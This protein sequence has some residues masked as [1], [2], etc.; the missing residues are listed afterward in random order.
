MARLSLFGGSKTEE[1]PAELRTILGQMQKEREAFESLILRGQESTRE[2]SRF[3]ESMTGA[4]TALAQLRTQ[5]E[6]TQV[7]LEAMQ[8]LVPTMA[9]LDEQTQS[10]TATQRRME[11][12]ATNASEDV[13][14][15]RADV[16]ELR[17]TLEMALALKNDLTGFLELGGGFKALRID[18]D[19]L[20][21]QLRDL[22]QGFDRVR[23]RQDEIR[24]AGDG[25]VSRLEAFVERHRQLQVTVTGTESRVN[26]LTPTLETLSQAAAQVSETRR[27]LNTVK[28]LGDS[29]SQKVAA[30]E[31]QRDAVDRALGQAAQLNQVMQEIN[32]KVQKQQESAKELGAIEA[33]VKDLVTLHGEALER[34][35]QITARQEEIARADQDLRG[36]LTAARDDV[37]QAVDRFEMENRGLEA[38][39]QRI[40][41]LRAAVTDI[42]GRFRALEESRRAIEEIRARAEGLGT[43]VG[44]MSEEIAQLAPQAE[45]VHAV[46]EDADQLAKAVKDLTARMAQVETTRSTI[47]AVLRDFASLKGTHEALQDATEQMKVAAGEVARVRQEHADT[48]SWLSGTTASVDALRTQMAELDSLKPTVERVRGEAE[49]VLQAA[50]QIESRGKLVEEVQGRLADLTSLGSQLEERTRALQTRMDAADDRFQAVTAHAEEAE[51][52]EKAMPTVVSAV[53]RSERR[54]AEVDGA[55]TALESR[56]VDLEGVA[57]RTRKLGQEVEQRQAALDK[58]SEHLERAAKLREEA[59]TAAQQL[60]ERTGQLSGGLETATG[61]LGDLTERLEELEGR[62]QNLRFMQKRMGQFEERLA[63]W[64]AAEVELARALEQV[65][66]RQAT[67]DTLQA[68]I[69]R[70]FE[71]AE[72]T[73]DDVKA[74][75]AAKQ[76]VTETRALLENVLG[77]VEHAHSVANTL[78]HKKRQVEQAEERVG[79]AEALLIDIQ[80]SLE[81]L[82]GQKAFLDQVLEQAGALQFQAK[83]AEALIDTLRKERDVTDRV[84]A[85]VTELRQGGPVAKGA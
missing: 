14:R 42:E 49:R 30:L 83:Q 9:T 52:I 23:E 60:E 21:A 31:Q 64:E 79:R 69:Q 43:Q 3:G 11:S 34:S 73:V 39:G 65:G 68:G 24:L 36:Q 33:R 51:R 19:H 57:E 5:M 28:A 17:N 4:Q 77:L 62:T 56:R 32:L 54:I 75:T 27:Q 8:R 18:A 7:K 38:A 78:E 12:Q 47:D 72:H 41:D 46:Q 35:K 58:A 45:R 50:T 70:V 2:V 67:I 80:S 20:A 29:I 61:R 13:K 15:I 6:A 66:H 10:F 1:L 71:T 81:T 40:T 63:K 55:I 44:T 76:E 16:D 26:A 25:A 59:A 48:E 85:A 74:I 22:T 82:H 37:K 53:D 84:R